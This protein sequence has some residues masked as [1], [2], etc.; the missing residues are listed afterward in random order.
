MRRQSQ[1]DQ[2]KT[3]PLSFSSV[4]VSLL[5]LLVVGL[6]VTFSLA[7][8]LWQLLT[9]LKSSG[10]LASLPPLLPHHPTLTHY[11]AIFQERPFGRILLN[12]GVVAAATTLLC[13]VLGAPAAF[14]IARMPFV[15]RR[16]LL[17]GA[18]SVSM[19]PPIATVTPLFLVIRGLGLRDTYPALILPYATFALPLT[20]WMLTSFFREVPQD[21][22]RAAQVDGCTPL[23]ALLKVFLPVSAPGLVSV[24]I[25]VFIFSWNEFLFAL[26]F[27]ATEASRTVPVEISLFPGLHE[28]PWGEISAA[29]VVVSLPLIL[30]VF[31]FQRRIISGLTAGAIKG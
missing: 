27:T 28:V 1:R 2:T 22:Y 26:T 20:L 19:F 15:G 9:S 14:A 8:Y 10:E 17:L 5:Y 16:F 31:L 12:S 29:S 13:L 11:A 30:L 3:A 4:S 21:L 7:P 24:A 25:L 23:Q 18:L 6:V